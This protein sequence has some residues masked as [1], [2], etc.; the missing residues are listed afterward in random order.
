MT[1]CVV[2]MILGVVLLFGFGTGQRCLRFWVVW[3]VLLSG[4]SG[5]LAGLVVGFVSV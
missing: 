2:L 1:V 4:F 3:V 5:I